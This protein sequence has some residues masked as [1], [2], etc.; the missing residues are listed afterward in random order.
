MLDFGKQF[1]QWRESRG[2]TAYSLAKKTG[3]NPSFLCNIEAGRRPMSDELMQKLAQIPE[4]EVTFA[5]LRA[6]KL[7]SQYQPQELQ[8][9]EGLYRLPLKMTVSA[10][11]MTPKAELDE[12][13]YMDWYGLQD[14]STDLFCMQVRGDSMWPPVPDGAILLVR[15]VEDLKNGGKYVVETE[16]EQM[17]FKLI[18]FDKSGARLVPL[19]PHYPAVSLDS[20]RL[21]RLYQVLSFKVDWS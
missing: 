5:M 15:E 12:P 14:L 11:T 10:G 3:V 13:V 18:R 21:K 8:A 6:W 9:V 16:D 17:T 19:N 7:Q 4:L 1:K 20:I 2:V